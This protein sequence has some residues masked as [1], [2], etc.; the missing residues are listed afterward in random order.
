MRVCAS[1]L[2]SLVAQVAADC[3]DG[4]FVGAGCGYNCDDDCNCGHCNTAPGCLS[5]DQC[6]GNCNSG[7]NAKWCPSSTPPSPPPA[8]D[9]EATCTAKDGSFTGTACGYACDDDCNCGRCNTA[10]GCLSEDQCLGTCNSGGNAKWCGPAPAPP[11]PAPPA[12]APTPKP[13]WSTANSRL[14][15][16]GSDIVLH[17]LGTTCTEYLLRGMGMRCFAKYH[18]STPAN[19]LEVDVAQVYPIVDYLVA[20]AGSSVVP[21]V[22][23][24]LTASSW[25]GVNTSASA[26][27]MA[28]YPDLDQQ[29]QQF[30]ADLVE[31]YSSYNIV[32]ILDLHWTDDDTDN[33]E[34]AGKS[35]TNCVSFWGSVAERFASNPYVFFELYNEPHKVDQ[36]A[37]MNGNDQYSGMLEMLQAVRQHSSNPV[38]IAGYGGYAYDADSLVQLDAQLGAEKNVLYNFHPYMGPNQAGDSKKCPAGLESALQ[39][40]LQGTDKPLIVTEF[41]QSCNPTHGA[42]QDCPGEYDGKVMGYDETILTIADKY[43]VSW[44]PWAWRPAASGPNSKNCQDLNGGEEG[45]ALYH[46]TDGNGA[47][48]SG[49]WADR[50]SVV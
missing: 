4:S 9:P 37:W 39:T 45:S 30:I 23:I 24:P 35:P 20:I 29:Y 33:A 7:G 43:A 27:N 46:D 12:P 19:V 42:A 47:D 31:I 13:T 32:T 41:G 40:I 49:L 18:W 17:G 2:A 38:I 44:L 5:E 6:L 1:F 22:R 10:P 48:W 15:K 14:Q 28:K 36:D 8:P 11:P 21:S 26:E 34:M 25:L 50:K 16:D 3:S